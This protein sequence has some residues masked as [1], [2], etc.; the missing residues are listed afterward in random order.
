MIACTPVA[1][2]VGLI[3]ENGAVDLLVVPFCLYFVFAVEVSSH[4]SAELMFVEMA[5]NVRVV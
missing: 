5:V 3:L 1:F 4:M 2:N